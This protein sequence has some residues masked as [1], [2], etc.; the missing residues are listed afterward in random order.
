MTEHEDFFKDSKF[1]GR[2]M[3]II[4]ITSLCAQFPVYL[5]LK[6]LFQDSEIHVCLL[7]YQNL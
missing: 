3:W 7:H 6:F 2:T 5:I 4:R 1:I